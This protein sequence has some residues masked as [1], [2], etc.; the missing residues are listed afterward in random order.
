MAVEL[1]PINEINFNVVSYE[2]V[3]CEAYDHQYYYETVDATTNSSGDKY[4]KSAGGEFSA[5]FYLKN[6][7][8]GKGNQVPNSTVYKLV[9]EVMIA[10]TKCF[11]GYTNEKAVTGTKYRVKICHQRA[12]GGCKAVAKDRGIQSVSRASKDKGF[13]R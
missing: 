8:N 13:V 9:E 10:G 6:M 11:Y 4:I 5:D 12:A 7:Y 3:H 1:T 2:N